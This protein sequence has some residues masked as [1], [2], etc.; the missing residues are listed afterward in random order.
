VGQITATAATGKELKGGREGVREGVAE[1]GGLAAT[2][3]ELK[4]SGRRACSRDRRACAATGK[5]LKGSSG[6]D[7]FRPLWLYQ[8]AN[9]GCNW[10]R[11]ERAGTDPR[12]FSTSFRAATGKELKDIYR[13]LIGLAAR[14]GC[15]WERIERYSAASELAAPPRGCNWERIESVTPESVDMTACLGCNWERIESCFQ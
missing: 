2:G 7:P 8:Y 3:K 14:H 10:E 12:R 6:I 13:A 15:N 9:T 1:G 11:I 4:A 5:E